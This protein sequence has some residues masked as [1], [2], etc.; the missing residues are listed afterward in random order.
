MEDMKFNL[1]RPVK[2]SKYLG[3]VYGGWT[4]I[5]AT[6]TSDNHTRFFLRKEFRDAGRHFDMTFTAR[7]NEMT[8]LSRGKNI[9]ELIANKT[10]LCH[11]KHVNVFQNTIMAQ[12]LK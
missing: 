9:N 2:R 4:V 7:D 6:R 10:V 12:F 3:R 11:A 1:E 5:R 8:K